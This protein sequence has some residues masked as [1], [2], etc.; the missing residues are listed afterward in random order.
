MF[1][2]HRLASLVIN[3]IE[4]SWSALLVSPYNRGLWRQALGPE[5][6]PT[7]KGYKP[8][9]DR[10][11]PPPNLS[12]LTAMMPSPNTES[13][14]ITL[15]RLL[16]PDS[17]NSF[18]FTNMIDDMGYAL[19]ANPLENSRM[20]ACSQRM[21]S[22][23]G[24]MASLQKEMEKHQTFSMK[25]LFLSGKS[26][27]ELAKASYKTLAPYRWAG[28]NHRQYTRLAALGTPVKGRFDYPV[29]ERRTLEVTKRMQES[30]KNLREFW[31]KADEE[32]K[33]KTGVYPLDDIYDYIAFDSSIIGSALILILPDRYY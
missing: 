14:L 8:D 4:T 28:M 25:T 27:V 1:Y 10:N 29:N 30:E 24:L 31:R 19:A 23:L 22:D 26:D 17:R 9:L 32:Y 11:M 20:S 3:R 18:G 33:G 7:N 6:S 15:T 2:A 12:T 13:N 21:F 16:S 5:A